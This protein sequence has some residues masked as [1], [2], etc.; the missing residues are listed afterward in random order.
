[1]K[2][3]NLPSH[4]DKIIKCDMAVVWCHLINNIFYP[5]FA[6]FFF[7]VGVKLASSSTSH[8]IKTRR[9]CQI[10]NFVESYWPRRLVTA[11]KESNATWKKWSAVNYLVKADGIIWTVQ[12]FPSYMELTRHTTPHHHLCFVFSN[13]CGFQF[14]WLYLHDSSFSPFPQNKE[15]NYQRKIY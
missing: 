11:L 15:K 3:R 14:G 12:I 13:L 6:L 8:V 5:I 2:D 10:P 1:M 9:N 7:L 4:S